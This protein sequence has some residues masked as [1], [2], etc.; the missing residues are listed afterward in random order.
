MAADIGGDISK[1]V[2]LAIKA[3]LTELNAYVDDE[4]PDYIMIM[5]ANRKKKEQMSESLSLFLG[6]N[7][8]TFTKWLYELLA[9]LKEKK[10]D[11][12]HSVQPSRD[13]DEESKDKTKNLVIKKSMRWDVKGDTTD[14]KGVSTSTKAVMQPVTEA[15]IDILPETDDILDEEL[16]GKDAVSSAPVKTKNISTKLVQV[17][18]RISVKS[19]KSKDVSEKS[20]P[21]KSENTSHSDSK[22]NKT[23][24]NSSKKAI[25]TEKSKAKRSMKSK[26]RDEKHSSKHPKSS[27][28]SHDSS[29]KHKIK[30]MKRSSVSNHEELSS[31]VSVACKS[32]HAKQ[33]ISK[34]DF[35][36]NV[37]REW[38]RDKGDKDQWKEDRNFI[39]Q[40]RKL[41]QSQV[42]YHETDEETVPS[43]GTPMGSV[44]KSSVMTVGKKH[45]FSSDESEE[46][47]LKSGGMVSKVAVPE[48]KS[49]LPPGKQASRSLL[50]KAVSEAESSVRL[51]ASSK[52]AAT[53]NKVTSSSKSLQSSG[54]TAVAAPSKTLV[55]NETDVGKKKIKR[56]KHLDALL[57]KQEV[58]PK[59][60]KTGAHKEDSSLVTSSCYEENTEKFLGVESSDFSEAMKTK[61]TVIQ[62]VHTTDERRFVSRHDKSVKSKNKTEKRLDHESTS[63]E[64]DLAVHFDQRNLTVKEQKDSGEVD[65]VEKTLVSGNNNL[66]KGSEKLEKI[67]KKFSRNT[68]QSSPCFIVTLDGSA[69]NTKGELTAEVQPT[70]NETKVS[71]P[72]FQ[73][74]P[75]QAPS[76]NQAKIFSIKPKKL[77]VAK[78]VEVDVQ[79]S[80]ESTDAELSAMREKLLKMQEEAK[81]L[82]DIQEEQMKLI[83]QKAELSKSTSVSK[84][85][86][87]KS[88]HIA[89][90]H[91]S[92]TEKQL[93]EHFG[94]CGKVKRATILRD[95]YTGQ[96]KG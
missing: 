76:S 29:H 91:F 95:A 50:L 79:D 10:T 46:D 48:R 83:K 8:K 72:K 5:I 63:T 16:L 59:K 73:A 33:D 82:K 4:L 64:C 41:S 40:S 89:N 27:D 2:Q 71:K 87:Q 78:T 11:D 7:A 49:R 57:R 66:G 81:K 60:M 47:T 31:V 55:Q 23:E 51:F 22:T 58:L 45:T 9:R 75:V 17:E 80:T 88:L 44:V 12:A 62:K 85:D 90:V 1:N 54:S 56:K 21:E 18:H 84:P 38:D 65:S 53:S 15:V 74:T 86:E 92:A 93:T 37:T 39:V 34:K 6:N 52:V 96:P 43:R 70:T 19:S 35:S 61:S 13:A 77:P 3:K 32:K 28:K 36:K 67:T 94:I 25:N 68:R 14:E 42:D 26:E 20:M 24:K 69:S 30:K